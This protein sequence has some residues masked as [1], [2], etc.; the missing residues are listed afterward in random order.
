MLKE[1]FMPPA[2][3]LVIFLIAYP[4]ALLVSRK[5]ESRAEK[6]KR[7]IMGT[8]KKNNPDAL[9]PVDPAP[10]NA[11]AAKNKAFYLAGIFF[12]AA[13][14]A[15]SFILLALE[16]FPGARAIIRQAYG[17][18]CFALPCCALY[19]LPMQP[20]SQNRRN[21]DAGDSDK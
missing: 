6:R 16:I 7:E 14:A 11:R 19:L 1:L 9:P 12:F 8:F 18:S 2:I 4:I 17:I 5:I 15:A 10:K 21:D 20:R 13:M 3:G